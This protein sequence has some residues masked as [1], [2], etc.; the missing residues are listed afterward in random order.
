MM[1]AERP[2]QLAN[3]DARF[4]LLTQAGNLI[5]GHPNL[6][7]Q[8]RRESAGRQPIGYRPAE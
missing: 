2:R 8:A 5:D 3:R 1:D 7:L 4:V 6:R